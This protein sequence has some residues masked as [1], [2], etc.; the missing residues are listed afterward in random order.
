MK[1]RHF[2]MLWLLIL[3]FM[4]YEYLVLNKVISTP[5]VLTIIMC[6]TSEYCKK[7]SPAPGRPI[8][9]I[10]GWLG[11][12]IMALTNAYIIRKR[13]G[14]LQKLGNLQNWL[15]WHIFFGLLGPTLVLF[16]CNFKVGGLVA[17]SFWSM[18][19]SF[20]SG[21]VGRYFYMQLIEGK[22]SLK[23]EIEEL[24]AKFD[25]FE[26]SCKGRLHPKAIIAAKAGAFAMAGGLSGDA[27][28][29]TSVWAFLARSLAG[30]YRMATG[31]PRFPLQGGGGRV[32]R[33][34]LRSW[35]LLRRR[36]L[37]MHYYQIL[38]GY[39]RTFHT[40]FAVWMYVVAIIHIISS[41]IFKVH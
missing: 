39:W 7:A 25:A 22:L 8:S 9:Y 4:S 21:I 5:S 10:L 31:L 38:F 19:V 15:N 3:T 34:Q 33:G 28:K 2:T 29:R 41:L 17:I 40:P 11:F 12:S 18:V 36:L 30:S 32:L 20:V 1:L 26:K 6:G 23:K 13:L 16:H 37:A 27:L 24:D 14:A 35:A